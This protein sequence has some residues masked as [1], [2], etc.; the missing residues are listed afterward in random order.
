[1]YVFFTVLLVVLDRGLAGRA[2]RRLLWILP[3]VFMVWA[4][5]H[6]GFVAGLAVLTLYVVVHAAVAIASRG[7][8]TAWREL[9]SLGGMVLASAFAMLLNP[10]GPRLLT[11]IA[12]AL[13]PPRPEIS[14]WGPMAPPDPVFFVFAL[15]LG[16]TVF[17]L[18]RTKRPR[19]WRQVAV[20]SATAYEAVLHS[21]HVVFFGIAAGLFVPAYVDGVRA[22]VR[23]AS[24]HAT[25][26]PFRAIA[27]TM[28]AVF[29][30]VLSFRCRT[31]WVGK[32]AYPVDAI[33]YLAEHDLD[34]KIVA[35]FGWAQYTLAALPDSRVAFDGRLRTCYPQDIADAYFDFILGNGRGIR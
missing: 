15:L 11:W 26:R 10:Y 21:R 29:F 34:G 24:D 17:V 27:W 32:A 3:P 33:Q 9:L 6:G 30:A 2:P 35:D 14:E 22:G 31:L 5:T 8:R 4:N 7:G 18:V 12:E 23:A 28:A 1:T 20:L 16:V 19:D 13:R 25:V